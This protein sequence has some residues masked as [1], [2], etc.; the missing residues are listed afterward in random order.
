VV[1]R[2]QDNRRI[3][4]IVPEENSYTFSGTVGNDP[5]TMEDMNFDGVADISIRQF[6]PA[7]P[8]IPYFCWVYDARRGIFVEDRQLEEITSAIFDQKNKTIVSEWRSNAGSYG[9]STYQYMSGRLTLVKEVTKTAAEDN[10]D[11]ITVTKVLV[12]GR[13]KVMSKTRSEKWD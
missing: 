3:Q 11:M 2:N 6:L 8:N 10:G 9:T 12:N 1:I 4:K 5:L 7:G 13:M